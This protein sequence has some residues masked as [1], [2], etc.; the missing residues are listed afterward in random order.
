VAWDWL[1]DVI[2]QTHC[3]WNGKSVSLCNRFSLGCWF[4]L[5][6]PAIALQKTLRTLKKKPTLLTLGKCP[7]ITWVVNIGYRLER[8][9]IFS[10]LCDLWD[11][12]NQL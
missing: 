12:S 5:M 2:S 1:V 7:D 3:A 4:I 8:F 10:V 11:Q 6:S 9:C